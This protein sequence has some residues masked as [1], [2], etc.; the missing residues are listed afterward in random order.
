MGKR[1]KEYRKIGKAKRLA[2]RAE[3]AEMLVAAKA[4]RDRTR[5]PELVADF[6]DDM[7]MPERM[8]QMLD[9]SWLS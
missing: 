1:Y 7:Y 5:P 4:E 6:A 9:G 2:M 3:R 8:K